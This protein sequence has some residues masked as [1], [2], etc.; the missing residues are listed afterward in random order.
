THTLTAACRRRRFFHGEEGESEYDGETALRALH[1][2]THAD[3]RRSDGRSAE[4]RGG[5]GARDEAFP[6]AL[7]ARSEAGRRGEGAGR[8]AGAGAGHASRTATSPLSSCS[9][10]WHGKVVARAS[11]GQ[12]IG[13]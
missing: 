5:D 10:C 8:E 11:R 7:Q 1:D 2:A 13:G 12:L 3:R 9:R 6:G 4:C